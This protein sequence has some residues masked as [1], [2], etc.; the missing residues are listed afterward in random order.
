[1][2]DFVQMLKNLLISEEY[3]CSKSEAEKLIKTQSNIVSAGMM[4]YN[5]NATAMA[6]TSEGVHGSSIGGGGELPK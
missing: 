5:L 4:S 3:N 1:M 2:Y 6:L